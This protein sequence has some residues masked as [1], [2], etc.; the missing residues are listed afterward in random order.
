M[1]S[2]SISVACKYVFRLTA[3]YWITNQGYG[4]TGSPSHLSSVALYLG[5]EPC[6]SSICTSIGVL[7]VQVLFRQL[8]CEY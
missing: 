3:W 8:Y 7:K 4:K 1:Q 2:E 5:V 6:K